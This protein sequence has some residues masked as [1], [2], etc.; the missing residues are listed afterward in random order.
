MVNLNAYEDTHPALVERRC[1]GALKRVLVH[2]ALFIDKTVFQEPAD[3]S[4]K[5]EEE[6][7][8]I[9]FEVSFSPNILETLDT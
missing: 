1:G 9:K 5:L 2:G 6:G 4:N 8:E 3:Y 7:W